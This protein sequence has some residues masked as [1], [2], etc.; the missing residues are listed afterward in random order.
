MENLLYLYHINYQAFEE[1]LCRLEQ[2]AVFNIE[3]ETKTFESNIVFD[4]SNSAFIKS[5]MAEDIVAD[6]FEELLK[7]V[8]KKAIDS[9]DFLIMYMVYSKDDP[10]YTKRKDLCKQVGLL[11]KGFPNF[12]T[13]SVIY[14]ITHFKN[15]WLFGQVLLNN[16]L[17]RHHDKKPYS[18]SS[19]LGIHLAK[20]LPNIGSKGQLDKSMV[21][22]CCGVGTVLL[23]AAFAGYNIEG[24]ELIE[25]VAKSAQKN[26][27]HFGYDVQV[28]LGDIKDIN[29]KYDVALV[30]LPYGISTKISEEE[31]EDIIRNACR[32]GKRVVVVS[33][34]DIRPLITDM[35]MTLVDECS[36]SKNYDHIFHRYVWVIE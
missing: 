35:N 22:P 29:K 30:D 6:S 33:T 19:S 1:P 32:I 10:S 16:G 25:K 34:K 15:K 21:D 23:E 8:E 17:W 3:D 2:R 27:L 12:K 9:E 24:R 14:G 5:R 11:F 36:V 31:Q 4:P 28:N 13:P 26:M 7:H 20:S 18:Y